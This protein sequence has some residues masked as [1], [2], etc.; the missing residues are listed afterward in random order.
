MPRYLKTKSAAASSNSSQESVSGIVK[1][2]IET[3]RSKG[4]TA[5]RQYSEK[6]D[7]WSPPSFKLSKSDIENVIRAVPEQ[8]IKDIK[9]VQA[10]VR[11][12]AQA[13]RNSIKDFE[14][15]TQPGVHLGQK[16]VPISSVG[17]YIPGGRYPLLASAHM[18]I[19]TAKVA[20]VK[21]VVACTPPIA[22]KIPNATVAASMTFL[23]P[24]SPIVRS[25]TSVRVEMSSARKAFKVKACSPK[26]N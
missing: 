24:F 15:E 18:T 4:D 9:E 17:A 8:T 2:V 1:E 3:I 19:L 6:F 13:Q 14:I 20:G 16:N 21:N 22:G 11:A 26:A 25:F 7:K 10:N 5:V 12:F 23:A